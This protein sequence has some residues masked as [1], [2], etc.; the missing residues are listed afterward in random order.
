MNKYIEQYKKMSFEEK[1]IFSTK[2]SILFNA[3]LAVGK[4]IISFFSSFFMIA[5]AI[6]NIF[7]MLSKVE[8]YYGEKTKGK[9]FIY[10]NKLI[11]I[12]VILAGTE[13][14]IYMGRLIYSNVDLMQ[15]DMI[16]GIIIACVS[17]VELAI[18]IKGCFNAFGKGH[19]YRNIKLINLSSALTAMVL[20]EI[21]IT[22]FASEE[23]TRFISGIFGLCVGII[24]ILIGIYILIAPKISI[25]DKLQNNY[26]SVNETADAEVVI[27]LTNSKLYGNY[28]YK[29]IVTNKTCKGVIEKGKSPIF[30]WNIYIK[31]LV[32]VLSEIL[33]FPYAVGALVFHFKSAKIIS[34]LDQTMIEKGYIKINTEEEI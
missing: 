23:D 29:G 3:L 1:T 20:T 17:F 21:A 24:I 34:I 33:I 31:I 4:F 15:Y 19:Y 10:R 18:A 12:F 7:M 25:V 8:C 26:Q 14:G 13:Y 2:F 32:I 28:T 16:L 27:P 9:D 22:S 11:G 30:K 6:I 5:A